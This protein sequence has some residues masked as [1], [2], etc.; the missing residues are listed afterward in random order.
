VNALKLLI[1]TWGWL[2]LRDRREDLHKDA[3]EIYKSYREQ[4]ATIYTTDYILDETFTLIFKR[5]SKDLAY[6]SLDGIEQAIAD[7][8]IN[9]TWIDETRFN[10][11]KQLRGKF[12]DKPNISF[13]DLTSMVVMEE[14]SIT[15]IL[16]NDDHFL[17]VGKNFETLP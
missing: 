17:Y 11:A 1:D 15:K 7:G 2:T 4:E 5:L 12:V 14:L 16:T 8:F 13:T 3:K 10:A 6:S 9:L